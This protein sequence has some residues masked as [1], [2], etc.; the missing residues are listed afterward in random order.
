[1]LTD[2]KGGIAVASSDSDKHW[3]KVLNGDWAGSDMEGLQSH[4]ENLK[5]AN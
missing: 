2:L 4:I 1:M 3:R 5:K